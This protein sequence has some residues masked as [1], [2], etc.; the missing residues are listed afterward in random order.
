MKSALAPVIACVGMLLTAGGVA[1]QFSC[2]PG[3]NCGPT[4]QEQVQ[5]WHERPQGPSVGPAPPGQRRPTRAEEQAMER[6]AN[7]AWPVGDPRG[8]AALDRLFEEV[9]RSA[10]IAD[11][12]AGALAA[13]R[14]VA[15]VTRVTGRLQAGTRFFVVLEDGRRLITAETPGEAIVAG[16]ALASHRVPGAG[17]VAA[18]ADPALTLITSEARLTEA[19]QRWQRW[20]A[21][22]E[23]VAVLPCV[24]LGAWAGW[25]GGPA[26]VAA[27]M[28]AGAAACGGAAYVAR[29]ALAPRLFPL[30][31][32]AADAYGEWRERA[33]VE[34]A[35]LRANPPPAP[36]P[37]PP[38]RLAASP[39][40]GPRPI[41]GPLP[42]P[43]TP[44]LLSGGG[45]AAA[46]PDP[47]AAAAREAALDRRAAE[48]DRVRAANRAQGFE[49]RPLLRQ[50]PDT[51]IIGGPLVVA[52]GGADLGGI[53]A[54]MPSP[55][56]PPPVE[57]RC[58]REIGM[59]DCARER[60]RSSAGSGP[61]GP[62]VDTDA[63]GRRSRE[64]ME[65]VTRPPFTVIETCHD[66]ASCFGRRQ[67]QY[68]RP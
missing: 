43:D 50:R 25:G 57:R 53:A 10:R 39:D 58:G 13:V 48:N 9:A 52:P 27:G 5:R 1:A 35:R 37:E 22:A 12:G 29:E 3:A 33:Q 17:A 55:A 28:D 61:G 68:R 4:V 11:A 41:P 62:L 65:S 51:V 46:R 6:R 64:S 40:P 54:P 67:E 34:Q 2:I 31:D 20:Q 38:A 15:P 21:G 8:E 30:T 56:R 63:L 19:Q 49:D 18:V 23:L 26:T 59:P 47:A 66:P 16:V 24:G 44:R 60:V 32:L 7:R 45:S 42:P 36:R 14:P